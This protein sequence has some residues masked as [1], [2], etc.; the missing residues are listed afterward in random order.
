MLRDS[1]PVI[2]L[3]AKIPTIPQCPRGVVLFA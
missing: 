1:R 3:P 2:I